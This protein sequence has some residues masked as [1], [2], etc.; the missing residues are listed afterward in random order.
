MDQI[1]SNQIAS[2]FPEHMVQD[3]PLLVAFMETYYKYA[4]QRNKAVGIV[5]NMYQDMDIDLTQEDYVVKFYNEYASNLPRE[6]AMDRRNFIKILNQIYTA[7]GTEK[8]LKLIFQAVF[9]EKIEISFPGE[10]RLRASDGV[11]I[12]ENYITLSVQFGVLPEGVI[13]LS[14]SND[15]GDYTF[16]TTRTEYVSGDTVRCYFR[17]FTNIKFA[18][19]QRVFYFNPLGVMEFA[20]DLIPSPSY[21]SVI[22]PGQSWQVGQVIVV[23]GTTANTVAKVTSVNSTGGITGVQIIEYGSYHP[24][25]QVITLSPYPNKPSSTEVVV[26]TQLVSSTPPIYLHNISIDDYVSE[27][28]ESVIGVSD[29]VTPNSYFLEDYVEQ[30]YSGSNVISQSTIQ[31]VP[32]TADTGDLTIQEWLASRATL[33]YKYE[34]VV[35][36]QGYYLN[37]LGQLSNQSIKLQDNYFYQAFSYLIETSR[38]I[39]VDSVT[40]SDESETSETFIK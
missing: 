25:G 14:V 38:D 28:S 31:S 35:N 26:D 13:T 32:V 6:V 7:K 34:D 12:R 18:T 40:V 22:T 20:G 23:P 5:Q 4:D 8:A 10:S 1:T 33:S 30:S 16:E 2:Q 3:A 17:S 21:L 39:Y 29:S 9:N 36:L 24:D 27:I 11:W 15:S 19:G 37:E